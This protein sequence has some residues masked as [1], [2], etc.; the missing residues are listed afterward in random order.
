[1]ADAENKCKW[2]NRS[3]RSEK[4]LMAH[5]C[6][7]KRRWADREMSHVRL[8]FRVYQMFYEMTTFST[9]PKTIEDFIRSQY[10][11]GFTK[12]GR[13]CQTNEY[14]NPTKYAE[15]LISRSKKLADWPKDTTYNDFL[16]EYVK[17][18][19]GMKALERNII[20]LS[21]WEKESGIPWSE[22]FKQVPT[23][24]AVHDIKAAKISPWLIYLSDTGVELLSRLSDEQVEMVDP[25]IDVQFWLSV[26]DS[27]QEDTELVK[28][29]CLAAGI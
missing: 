10:Y 25:V 28:E 17:K 2:C 5:M 14:L 11:E 9:K 19:P 27:K 4:T 13:A 1:M 20:Y 15:W 23:P 22:Y 18:E 6:V 16:S 26:F 24:R 3:F 21:E 29:T 7:R 8:G 12:F